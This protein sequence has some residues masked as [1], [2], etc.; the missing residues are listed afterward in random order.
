MVYIRAEM[1]LTG[2]EA[3]TSLFSYFETVSHYVAIASLD[4]AMQTRLVQIHCLLSLRIKMCASQVMGAAAESY[5]PTLGREP[6]LELSIS[7]LILKPLESC[8]RRG[9]GVVGVRGVEYAGRIQ[10]A[11]ST[12]Q[13]P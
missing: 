12:K 4:M 5:R 6:K 7:F 11:E 13:G 10:P 1:Y 2:R 9:G 3:R 8:R